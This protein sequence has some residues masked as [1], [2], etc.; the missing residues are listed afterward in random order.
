MKLSVPASAVG[1]EGSAVSGMDF[2]LYGG[3]VTWD[4]IGRSSAGQ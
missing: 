3:R 1:L 4:A 2:S